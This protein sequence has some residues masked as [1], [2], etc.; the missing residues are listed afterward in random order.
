MFKPTQ[1]KDQ[2]L[3]QLVCSLLVSE[4]SERSAIRQALSDESVRELWESVDWHRLYPMFWQAIKTDLDW[5][6]E[7]HV[8]KFR[9]AAH[10]SILESV[11][12]QATLASLVSLLS[13]A[14]IPFIVFKGV[15]LSELFYQSATERHGKDIDIWVS[16]KNV[17]KVYEL[18]VQ[19]G[20]E[21]LSPEEFPPNGKTFESYMNVHKDLVFYLPGPPSVE[22]ELH[23]RLDKNKYVYQLSFDQAMN[24]SNTVE[25]AGK[26]L[27]TFSNELYLLYLC[28]HGGLAL[29]GRF[30]WL[31]DW[32]QAVENSQGV[33]WQRFRQHLL[34]KGH[35]QLALLAFSLSQYYF[36]QPV[37][38]AFQQDR[39]N[40]GTRL[41]I[42]IIMM[43]SSKRRYPPLMLRW[44]L[45]LSLVDNAR[46]RFEQ[47]R[48]AFRLLLR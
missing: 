11:T 40:L 1:S 36:K 45:R 22:L 4:D 13:E 39:V 7:P 12:Q 38:A 37:P 2:R 6:P 28:T 25:F 8:R 19:Y 29:W 24:Q 3:L 14:K 18:L 30:K 5:L 10:N 17:A 47:F 43:Y 20:F 9:R 46:F 44:L 34:A 23:W 27:Q 33:D 21:L 16:P 41:V 31:L 35:L 15:V 48:L 42:R 32:Y 26:Q